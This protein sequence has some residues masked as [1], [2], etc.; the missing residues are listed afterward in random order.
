MQLS[1]NWLRSLVNP[2]L[3][4]AAL[5]HLVTMAGLEVEAVAPVAPAFSHIVVAEVKQVEKHPAADRLSVC[6]VDAGTGTLLQ[7]VCGAANVRANIKVPCALIGAVLP[8]DFKIKKSK[9][10]GVE[11]QGM[12]CAARELGLTQESD[13]IWILPETAPVGQNIR[14]YLHLDDQLLTLKLTPNRSD[15]LSVLGV[16]REIAALTNSPLTAPIIE[17]VLPTQNNTK[18]VI[19]E[20]PAACPRYVGR[21]I[22]N[23]NP[24]AQTPAWM[25]ERL[26]RS[27]QRCLHPVVDI[28]NY[29]LLELGQ[30]MHAFDLNQL[31]G[32]IQVRFAQAGEKLTLLNDQTIDLTPDMLVI[33]DEQKALAL[34]GIMGGAESA[35]S[36]VTTDI[37]L[38]SAFFQP[39]VIL[40][41][42]RRLRFTTDSAHRFE[43]G[44][45]F[46]N[47]KN[48]IERATQLVLEICGGAAGPITESFDQTTFPVRSAIPLRLERVCRVLGIDLDV[49]GLTTILNRLQFNFEQTQT[50]FHVTPPSYRF[51]LSIEEDL[52]EEVARV[53]GY[54]QIPTTPPRSDLVFLTRPEAQATQDDLRTTLIQR[55]YQE[56]VNYSFIDENIEQKLVSAD[57]TFLKLQN[58][59]SAQMGTMRA[60]LWG[61]L[62]QTLL[63]NLNR[64]Q[65]RCRIFEIGR[66]F[67]KNQPDVV[68]NLPFSQPVKIGGLVYGP[69]YAEQWSGEKRDVDFFDLKADIEALAGHLPL[70]FSKA[71][72]PALHPG[73][74]AQ[75]V[76]NNQV[77]GYLGRLHPQLQ[78]EFDLVKPVYVF[79]L[80]V[81]ALLSKK[82]PAYQP[83]SAYP[84]VRRD[85]AVLVDEQYHFAEI[86]TALQAARPQHVIDIQL[87]DVYRG[88]GIEPNQK[89]LAL[90]FVLQ[91]TEKTL[92]DEEIEH[93]VQQLFAVLET[94]FHAKL[95]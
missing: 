95:R 18:N 58:P 22:Q 33:A 40:G 14:D 35:V 13:G 54:D 41:K 67:L 92:S 10:R 57:T 29:V 8:G 20:A 15:C 59:I 93:S 47:T 6:Q 87:F 1:E 86:L 32:A 17:S 37:F 83:I 71:T 94:T 4:T 88:K 55:D 89:S 75:I 68:A 30:P 42:T 5:A 36:N 53:Y 70:Q 27:G 84:A 28:T 69:L 72:H 46:L 21:I 39:D 38:E 82:V 79:E 23:I 60:T 12:L 65:N 80:D 3:D 19:L 61:S 16:A 25:Q 48:A 78:Q 56:T 7:I 45:D 44:V 85:L 73:Q 49:A 50:C 74:S 31:S 9:L 77:I 34:A 66:V 91:D 81:E 26:E 11:S 51:D 24:N 76:L 62:I 2:N 63:F 52:I 64:Q 43:R 90:S